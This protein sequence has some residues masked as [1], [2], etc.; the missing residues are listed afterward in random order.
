ME[1]FNFIPDR[2]IKSNSEDELNRNSF[3]GQ[4]RKSLSTWEDQDSLVISLKGEWG[5]GKSSVINLLKEQFELEKKD[6]DPTIIEF[7]PWAYANQ[8]SLT[9]HFF[10]DI[11]SELKIKNA[12]KRDDKLARK[13][14]LYSQLINIDK[15]TKV[16][17]NIIPQ[18]FL[19]LGILGIS[20]NK[21]LDW[22]SLSP[23]WIENIIFIL[24]LLILLVQLSAGLLNKIASYFELKTI[25]RDISPQGIK[26]EIVNHLIERKKKLLII[27]DDI[28]RL[29]QKEI[30]EVFRLIRVNAD[31]PNT[32]YLLAYDSRIIEVNLE[33]QKGISGKDFLKKIVQVDFNLPYT[34]NEKVQSFLFKE[35]DKL[36]AKLPASINEYF[37]DGNDYWS[38]TYHS[39]YK[40]FFNNI[41]DVK[42]YINSLLFNIN[43]LHEEDVFEVNPIDF[44][45]LEVLRVFTPEFYDFMKF[46]KELFTDNSE[47]KIGI[48]TEQRKKEL[49]EGFEL[50]NITHRENVKKLVIH[51]F[52]QIETFIKEFGSTHYANDFYLKWRKEMRI[53]S[54]D[55]FGLYFTLNPQDASSELTQ[56]DLVKFLK[57]LDSD[58]EAKKMIDEF[59]SNKK[60]NP[61]IRRIQ[62]YTDDANKMPE[63][64]AICLIKVLNDVSDSIEDDRKGMFDIGMNMEIA[65]VL[66]Q[67]LSRSDISNTFEIIRKIII[68][69]DGIFS[70]LNLVA[71]DAQWHKESPEDKKLLFSPDELKE[72][73]NLLVQKIEQTNSKILL[74]NKHFLYIINSWRRWSQQSN[75]DKFINEL[76]K[77]PK[78]FFDFVR[79]FI[80]ESRSSTSGS[81][82]V[83][84]HREIAFKNLT[85]FVKIEDVKNL[86]DE[87]K[88][89][90]DMTTEYSEYISMFEHDY[91]RYMKNPES[92]SR[93]E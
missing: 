20:L 48:S 74:D 79:H 77:E 55:H 91:E 65:R 29:G 24:G 5:E 53:C 18:V 22:V 35:L 27:I 4:L 70:V 78:L 81:Y 84:V 2:A 68:D 76:K 28:D 67:I 14:K 57:S 72:L 93:Y 58:S 7:N 34:R 46:R 50:I 60:F 26:K 54:K 12:V 64:S 9:F 16:L 63:K 85:S 62:D 8:D 40:N 38:N 31:F 1:E 39:G 32:I 56:Y 25:S 75:I 19:L 59:I 69:S 15:E 21:L 17:K 71:I 37:A 80:S 3:A 83:T 23:E 6:D 43:L 89:D 30:C 73:Q 45:A 88:K 87:I 49:I 47:S 82:G 44:I 33:E 42:R 41:R 90:K 10:N 11:G 13:L 51:L 61:L 36:I 52:P 86:V 66:F 92:Y